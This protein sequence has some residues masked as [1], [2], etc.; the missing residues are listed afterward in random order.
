MEI[1]T[2]TQEDRGMGKSPKKKKRHKA[3]K[4]WQREGEEKRG[5][6]IRPC[7]HILYLFIPIEVHSEAGPHPEKKKWS[8]QIQARMEGCKLSFTLWG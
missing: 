3:R 6:S 7:I 2:Q 4:H 8:E 5:Q 1:D